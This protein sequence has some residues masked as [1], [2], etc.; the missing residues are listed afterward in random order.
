MI[1]GFFGFIATIFN[2]IILFV[3]PG[4]D[5]IENLVLEV[6][7]SGFILGIISICIAFIGYR[8]EEIPSFLL[9]FI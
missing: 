3:V 7:I 1:T 4:A 2:G 6:S 8:I 5:R 9:L